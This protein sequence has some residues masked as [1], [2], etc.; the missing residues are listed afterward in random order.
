MPLSY[1]GPS[2]NTTNPEINGPIRKAFPFHNKFGDAS[3]VVFSQPYVQQWTS[4]APPTLN[5]STTI[6]GTTVYGVGDDGLS[7]AGAGLVSFDRQ[8][9]NVPD[10]HFD[11]ETTSVTY[12]GYTETREPYAQ[13]TQ[14]QIKFEY[15]L[16]GPSLTYETPDEIPLIAETRMTSTAGEDAYLLSGNVYINFDGGG[17]TPTIEAYQ[18]WVTAGTYEI[19]VDCRV[20][21]YLGNIWARITRR[22]QAK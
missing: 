4:Y 3:H 19:V 8:W 6:G 21:Q 10:A 22:V 5:A 12:P 14:A 1:E 17:T 16:V 2:L 15:F 13:T 11:Y 20:E 7:D 18:V 9:A